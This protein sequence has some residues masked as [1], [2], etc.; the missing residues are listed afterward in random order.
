MMFHQFAV[1]EYV[2]ENLGACT[3]LVEEFIIF[4]T[5]AK[6]KAYALTKHISEV[7]TILFIDQQED[8]LLCATNQ[9]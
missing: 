7:I 4:R 5:Y 6:A 3:E 9:V 1:Q 2:S 8:F